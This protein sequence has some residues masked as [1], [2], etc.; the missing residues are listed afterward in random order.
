MIIAARP[1]R[2]PR[3][4]RRCAECGAKLGPH[5]YLYGAADA[6]DTPQALR[7][8]AACINPTWAAREPRI[9]AALKVLEP[10]S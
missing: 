8:C 9:A 5:L 2:N 4:P 10:L 6:G 1:V 3:R 7:L